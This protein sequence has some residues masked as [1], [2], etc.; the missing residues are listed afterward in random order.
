MIVIVTDTTAYLTRREAKELNTLHIPMTYTTGGR[1]VQENHAELY[2]EINREDF[3]EDMKTSQ[4]GMSTILHRFARLRATACEVL[5]ITISSRLSG[6]YSNAVVCA[7]ELGDKGIRVVNS[8][9]SAAGMA[10]MIREARRMIDAGMTLDETA[11]ALLALRD[12]I[13]TY[14]SVRDLTPLRRSGRLGF[15]RQSVGTILNQRPILTCKDGAVVCC[16]VARGTNEQLRKLAERVPGGAADVV[17]QC[18]ANRET[19]ERLAMVLSERLGR[20]PD[21]RTIG[22]VLATH[23]GFDVVGVAW[24]EQETH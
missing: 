21:I 10:I 14:F 2:T 12:R 23:L 3:D 9:T 16:D 17:V 24:L 8:R 15:V 18:A 6:T 1:T 20:I 5:C 13:M 11:D 4:P 22:P 19:A 7:R